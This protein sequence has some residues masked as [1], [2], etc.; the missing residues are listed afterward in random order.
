MLQPINHCLW[1]VV[2]CIRIA[3]ARVYCKRWRHMCLDNAQH[4][5]LVCCCLLLGAAH[6]LGQRSRLQEKQ[7]GRVGWV[8][9]ELAVTEGS[10]RNG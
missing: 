3:R 1:L 6:D 10:T 7:A 8:K 9:V 4:V 5:L 2:C